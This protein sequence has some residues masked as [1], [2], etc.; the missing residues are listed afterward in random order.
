MTQLP[1]D[2]CRCVN[3]ECPLRLDCLRYT[4][5]PTEVIL[6]YAE[7]KPKGKDGDVCDFQIKE[8]K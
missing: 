3:D 6:Y 8:R 2:I 4:S 1:Y 7:F 5:Q